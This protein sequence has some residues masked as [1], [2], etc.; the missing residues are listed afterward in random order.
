MSFS[1]FFRTTCETRELHSDVELR[2]RYYRNNFDQCLEALKKLATQTSMEIR[3]VNKTHGEVYL[4]GNGYDCIVTISQIN[5]IE[6]GIDLKINFFSTF[7]FGRP[8]KRAIAI[9]KF[10]NSVLKF[11]GVALHP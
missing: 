9:Y 3:D 4:I 10:L 7:G 11:K 2:T 1:S 8:Q 5:P 6:A